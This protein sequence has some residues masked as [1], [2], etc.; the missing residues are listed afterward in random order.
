MGWGLTKEMFIGCTILDYI[1]PFTLVGIAGIFAK[2]GFVGKMAGVSLAVALRYI[3]HV[4]AGAVLWHSAGKI[5]EGLEIAN[6]WLYSIVYNA[7]YMLPE[8][9]ITLIVSAILLK[10]KSFLRLINEKL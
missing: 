1:L 4:L 5:W 10:N 2:K 3:S 6:E 7:C 8:L 9:A